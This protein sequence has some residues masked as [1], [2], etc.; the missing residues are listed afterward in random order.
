MVA[1]PERG[2]RARSGAPAAAKKR[3]GT[4]VAAKKS[5]ARRAPAAKAPARKTAAK[6]V[7]HA[8]PQSPVLVEPDDTLVESDEESPQAATPHRPSRR[9]LIIDAAI[10]VFARRGF[11]EASIQEVADD[12]GMVATAVYYHFAGK[13]ELFEAALMRCIEGQDAVIGEA[14]PDHAPGSA[15]IFAKVIDASWKWAAANPDMARLLFLHSSGAAT[16]RTRTLAR[17]FIERHAQRAYDYFE[18]TTIPT[19]RRRA[20]AEYAVRTLI[21]RTVMGL[22]LAVHQLPMEGGLLAG[23]S[24]TR[25]RRAT[26]DVTGRLFGV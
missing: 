10:R 26:A 15:Q 5:T 17:E 6:R 19:N 24:D 9:H 11:S 14:R 12:A 22:T 16:P 13:E 25:V 18:T 3:A 23:V 7:V 2:S 8:E 4:S 1:T 21:V 20:A